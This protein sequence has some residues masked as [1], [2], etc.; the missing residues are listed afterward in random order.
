MQVHAFLKERGV[1]LNYSSTE[2]QK[3]IEVTDEVFKNAAKHK[4]SA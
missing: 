2:L 4:R 3:D 1:Y